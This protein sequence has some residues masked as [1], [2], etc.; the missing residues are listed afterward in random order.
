MAAER[1]RCV[2]RNWGRADPFFLGGAADR[3]FT[4]WQYHKAHIGA[5]PNLLFHMRHLAPY[6]AFINRFVAAKILT[7]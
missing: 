2:P 4:R 6:C 3:G 1:E 7:L 5:Q